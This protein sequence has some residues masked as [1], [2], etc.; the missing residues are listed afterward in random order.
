MDL[1]EDKL[2]NSKW[3]N[4]KININIQLKIWDNLIQFGIVF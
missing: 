2:I 3:Y 1:K 4:K